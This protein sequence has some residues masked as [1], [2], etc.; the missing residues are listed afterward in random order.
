M[1]GWAAR[2]REA[3]A[4][5]QARGTLPPP[6]P[7]RTLP[8]PRPGPATGAGHG[9]LCGAL[10]GGGARGGGRCCSGVWC[11]V[12]WPPNPPWLQSSMPVTACASPRYPQAGAD[13]AF[14][15]F[16]HVTRFLGKKVGGMGWVGESLEARRGWPWRAGRAPGGHSRYSGVFARGRRERLPACI[17]CWRAA[18][19][20]WL[21]PPFA[22]MHRRMAP[23]A[24]DRRCRWCCWGCT[25]GSACRRSRQRTCTCI[26]GSQRCAGAWG[27]RPWKR[28][29]ALTSRAA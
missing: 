7:A 6:N 28:V 5:V 24:L 25:M 9:H 21:P 10:H 11:V 1:A 15:L 14:E 20:P 18:H 3:S 29:D 23:P 19:P 17:A 12:V 8:C 22:H 2:L 26:A 4:A 16:T 13:W 27:W